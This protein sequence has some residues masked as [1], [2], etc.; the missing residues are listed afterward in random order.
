MNQEINLLRGIAICAVVGIH[1]FS[2]AVSNVTTGVGF[3]AY[4]IFHALMGFAVPCFIFMSSIL[5]SYTLKGKPLNVSIFYKKKVT[6]IVIPY[7]AWTAIFMIFKIVIGERS[8]SD[9]ANFKNWVNW[10]V[11][12]KTYTHLYYIVIVLQLYLFAPLLLP[13]VKW[14]QVKSGAYDFWTIL[15]TSIVLQVSFYFLNKFYISKFFKYQATML[16][17]YTYLVLFGIW[18]GYNYERFKKGLIR[19]SPIVW[20][21]YS[22]NAIVYVAYKVCLMRGTAI[23]STWYQMNWFA[24]TLLTTLILLWMCIVFRQDKVYEE[25]LKMIA[26]L[27]DYSF[28]IYLMHPIITYFLR[29]WIHLTQPFGILIV[30]TIGYILMMISCIFIINLLR[31]NQWTSLIIGEYKRRT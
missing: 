23:S 6:R 11:F 29:K 24:Y 9:L 27:G 1:T 30:L 4:P 19:Y 28:G 21:L 18:V 15:L 3:Y 31:M 17:W 16:I 26:I 2:I 13:F 10:V 5:L 8:L 22:F 25:P 20:L 7:L 12:G 14:L